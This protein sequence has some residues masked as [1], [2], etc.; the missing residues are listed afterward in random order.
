MYYSEKTIGILLKNV[1]VCVFCIKRKK[2]IASLRQIQYLAE[3]RQFI[4]IENLHEYCIAVTKEA[5]N[6]RSAVAREAIVTLGHLSEHLKRNLKTV[7]QHI[8]AVLLYKSMDT[9]HFICDEVSLALS[10]IVQ[11]CNTA[12]VIKA[13]IQEGLR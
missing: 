13:F 4:L 10:K 6:H 7:L 3:H 12:M 5:M 1:C 8:I 9:N 11:N 2:T